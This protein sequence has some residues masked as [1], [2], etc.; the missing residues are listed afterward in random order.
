M[1]TTETPKRTVDEEPPT[2]TVDDAEDGGTGAGRIHVL[3]VDDSPDY[4]DALAGVLSN[5]YTDIEVSTAT[6]APDAFTVLND[7]AVDC[8]VSDYRMPSVDGLEFLS[9][10]RD[11]FPHTSFIMFTNKGN[12]AVEGEAAAIG[13]TDFL[14]KTGDVDGTDHLVDRIRNAVGT[15]G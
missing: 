15:G 14:R 7:E 3:L 4:V 10:V 12:E 13:A 11:E 9:V 5:R 8:I 6:S 2:E 1:T